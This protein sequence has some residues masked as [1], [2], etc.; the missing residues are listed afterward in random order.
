MRNRYLH[1]EDEDRHGLTDKVLFGVAI[2]GCAW[3]AAN[4]FGACNPA[5]QKADSMAVTSGQI[6]YEDIDGD[7]DIDTTIRAPN[8]FHYKL[9]FDENGKP[10]TVK[11]ACEI[12]LEKPYE[13]C[14]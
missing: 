7:G 12:D 8:G 3:Y 2:F 11:Y 4:F 13:P 5:R 14:R 10:H 1:E 9:E 6:T